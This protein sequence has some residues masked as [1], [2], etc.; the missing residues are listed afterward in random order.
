MGAWVLFER[1]AVPRVVL[2]AV[3]CALPACDRL[4]GVSDLSSSGGDRHLCSGPD[5]AGSCAAGWADC[6]GDIEADGCETSLELASSCGACGVSCPP[7][8][9]CGAG[10]RCDFRS[11]APGG[12]GRSDCGPHGDESCCASIEVPGG[13]FLRDHDGVTTTGPGLPATVSAFRLD[14]YEVTVARMR[15][16]ADAQVAGWR[17]AAGS[18]KHTY[19]PG[20]G[21]NGGAEPGWLDKWSQFLPK[22]A[23]DWFATHHCIFLDYPFTWARDPAEM[24]RRPLSCT[25]WVEAYAF[26]IWDGGF[27]PTLAESQFAGAG[28]DEQR[29]YPWSSPP[30]STLVDDAHLVAC[31]AGTCAP[32]A[33]VGSRSPLGDG[34]WG[35]VDLAGNAVELVDDDA[36]VAPPVP[37]VD[38]AAANMLSDNRVS[39]GGSYN[40]DY[41][42]SRVAWRQ[43]IT[44]IDRQIERGIRCARAPAARPE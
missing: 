35:H 27:L 10:G 21:L 36:Q 7:D 9:V 4:A 40:F 25:H 5:C 28:G 6:D 43:S 13:T 23:E 11:C 26:C 41:G 14:R 37:C 39:R 8:Q 33:D 16:F 44:V 1:R 30:S 18:G 19:L 20:G 42:T 38:C 31:D 34:R 22:D 32:M 15:A 17:P 24:P 2:A 29:V 3:A 12:P